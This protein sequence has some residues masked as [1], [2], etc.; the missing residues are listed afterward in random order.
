[1]G[2]RRWA[3]VAEGGLAE[4][5]C[6]PCPHPS[7]G[8]SWTWPIYSPLEDDEGLWIGDGPPQLVHLRRLEA[9]NLNSAREGL[10]DLGETFM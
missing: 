9:S 6:R 1:M 2:R 3:E 5:Y 8:T 4:E 10:Q 7:F